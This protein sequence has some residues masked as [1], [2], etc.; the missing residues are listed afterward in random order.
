MPNTEVI[1]ASSDTA[2]PSG[3]RLIVDGV[4]AVNA[5]SFL[6]LHTSSNEITLSPGH[7][8]GPFLMSAS[9]VKWCV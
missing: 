1:A 7:L 6:S 9:E 2:T 8:G 4:G 3:G 5:V